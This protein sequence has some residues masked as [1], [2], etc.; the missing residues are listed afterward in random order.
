VSEDEK[1]AEVLNQYFS[2]V[3][4][5]EDI[6]NIPRSRRPVRR[7]WKTGPYSTAKIRQKI[8]KLKTASSPGPDGITSRL[9]QEMNAEIAS[10]L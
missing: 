8:A 2:T 3:F 5:R 9:L 1:M 4:T 10:E 7:R 6:T